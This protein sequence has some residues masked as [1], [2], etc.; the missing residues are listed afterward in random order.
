MMV[1][2]IKELEFLVKPMMSRATL[3]KRIKRCERVT[4]DNIKVG[5]PQKGIFVENLP[6]D[7]RQ[8]AIDYLIKKNHEKPKPEPEPQ[9]E[10]VTET[11]VAETLP[12]IRK[13]SRPARVKQPEQQLIPFKPKK[14]VQIKKENDEA[15][16]AMYRLVMAYRDRM[17]QIEHGYKAEATE[18][19]LVAYNSGEWKPDI[20]KVLGRV[21]KQTLYSKNKLLKDHND[22]YLAL[23]DNRCFS[24]NTETLTIRQ[25]ECFL[26]CYLQRNKP[27]FVRAYRGVCNILESCEDV[28]SEMTFRRWFQ[29][30]YKPFNKHVIVLAREGEKAYK[31]KVG[32]YITRDISKLKPGDVLVADGHKLNFMIRHPVTGKNT[33]MIY[34]SFFDWASRF[35]VGWQL[36][37]TENTISVQA[38]LWT[39]IMYMGK[40]PKCVYIDNGKAFKNKFFNNKDVDFEQYQG[41]YNRLGIGVQYAL[42]YNARAKVVERFYHT[43]NE[44]FERDVPSYCGS[45][46]DDK[47]AHLHR[48]EKFHQMMHL[49]QFNNYVPTMQE[50]AYLIDRYLQHYGNQP[51]EGLDGKKP[52]DILTPAIGPG[53]DV[54]SL[55]R[56]MLW[57]EECTPKNCRVKLYGVEYEADFL[58]GLDMKVSVHYDTSNMNQVFC[59]TNAGHQLG[60]AKPVKAIH[61]LARLFDDQVGMEDLKREMKRQNKLKKQTMETLKS[62]GASAEDEDYIRSLPGW[63]RK[64]DITPEVIDNDKVLPLKRTIKP[65]TN[66]IPMKAVQRITDA[67]RD[68]DRLERL[69]AAEEQKM[70]REAELAKDPYH[71][72]PEFFLTELDRYE[73]C[74]ERI[75]KDGMTLRGED[76]AFMA[77][78]ESTETYKTNYRNR[79]E[80]LRMLYS[81]VAV[82]S[83]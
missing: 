71:N 23:I 73:W 54:E 18:E 46:I 2:S 77:Y 25:K 40:M 13:P 41:F 4:F 48:N 56:E 8:L 51:H 58:H 12:A 80:D 10:P 27:T 26:K 57:R 49:K 69:A 68:R 19:F 53:I 20:F 65:E 59:Y 67:E 45:N 1:I 24:G 34:L 70:K 82:S 42:A 63:G 50:A 39:A 33:R 81:D 44:Q 32:P 29:K 31:D 28:P 21:A 79:F 61:P 35:P 17:R 16:L 22:D 60:I 11:P 75:V 47:P 14:P 72:K 78:F 15:A 36:M 30:K 37:P 38:A 64:V 76:N 6:D 83:M 52:F 62:V 55:S 7:L 66:V 74:F 9:P 43:M 5:R 3:M